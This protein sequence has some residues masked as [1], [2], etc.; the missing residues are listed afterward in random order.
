MIGVCWVSGP[1]YSVCVYTWLMFRSQLYCAQ[2]H[3]STCDAPRWVLNVKGVV[4]CALGCEVLRVFASLCVVVCIGAIM[5]LVGMMRCNVQCLGSGGAVVVSLLVDEAVTPA[6]MAAAVALMSVLSPPAAVVALCAP[7]VCVS[8]LHLPVALK[9]VAAHSPA[10]MGVAP[11]AV[12][13]LPAAS[14]ILLS[15][16]RLALSVGLVV[17]VGSWRW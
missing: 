6:A 2:G 17:V 1:V 10:S 3:V 15:L 7:A 5:L 16:R 9:T 4:V 8:V 12:A 13:S 11:V 14:A